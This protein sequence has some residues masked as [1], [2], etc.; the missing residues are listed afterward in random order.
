MN[1]EKVRQDLCSDQEISTKSPS[2]DVDLR[3][4]INDDLKPNETSLISREE[5]HYYLSTYQKEGLDNLE[6][7]THIR[8][9]NRC[10]LKVPLFTDNLKREIK[11]LFQK[12]QKGTPIDYHQGLDFETTRRVSVGIARPS[13]LDELLS[14]KKVRE[15]EIPG[16]RDQI[17]EKETSPTLRRNIGMDF[18]NFYLPTPL[19][20][21]PTNQGGDMVNIWTVA[22]QLILQEAWRRAFRPKREGDYQVTSDVLADLS[23]QFP[24]FQLSIVDVYQ[25]IPD[26]QII[27]NAKDT[28]N[29]HF[30][31][32]ETRRVKL[33]VEIDKRLREGLVSVFQD[34]KFF[35]TLFATAGLTQDAHFMENPMD[36][37]VRHIANTQKTLRSNE[38]ESQKW[39]QILGILNTMID[40]FATSDPDFS[41]LNIAPLD[42]EEAAYGYSGY[43]LSPESPTES[44]TGQVSLVLPGTVRWEKRGDILS[45]VAKLMVEHKKRK[46]SKSELLELQR[47]Y[48]NELGRM[49]SDSGLDNL[50]TN[51]KE[52]E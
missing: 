46:E 2:V 49:A 45:T 18:E 13:L 44:S 17:R 21:Y 26:I 29:F 42:P 14:R 40:F 27:L 1:I 15:T 30:E 51:N 5:A 38:Q 43:Y 7:L 33:Y 34:Y 41:D 52:T 19:S 47:S 36:S 9:F 32:L 20:F 31:D 35:R 4:I 39:D 22:G 23:R 24:P 11:V 16:V 37:S 50:L 3:E 28:N 6:R 12:A 25:S 10:K 8:F 48:E